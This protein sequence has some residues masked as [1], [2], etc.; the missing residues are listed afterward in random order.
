MKELKKTPPPVIAENDRVLLWYAW[1]D[2]SVGYTEGHGLFFVGGKEIGRVPCLA[3]C[4]EKLSGKPTLYYCDENWKMLGVAANYE[5]IEAAKRRAELIYPGVATRWVESHFT[6]EDADRHLAATASLISSAERGDV[7]TLKA[8]IASGAD[9]DGLDDQGWTA[10]FHAASRGNVDVLKPLLEAGA[11]NVEGFYALFLAT[12]AGH[13][14][15]VRVLLE[16]GTNLTPEHFVELRDSISGKNTGDKI[17][18]K[19][20]DGSRPGPD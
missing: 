15:A 11:L 8:A 1:L 10:L 2:G 13:V 14:E 17:I 12:S 16:A 4:E 9:L 5:S 6:D 7:P 3:I 20:L 19:L 18:L